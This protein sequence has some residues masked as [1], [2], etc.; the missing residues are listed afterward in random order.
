MALTKS[1]NQGKVN[2]FFLIILFLTFC[3]SLNRECEVF[4]DINS[5][6]T[7]I[8]IAIEKAG[9]SVVSLSTAKLVTQRHKDPVMG[10]RNKFFFKFF[11]EY[12]GS[13][14]QKRVE[15]P[16]GT[17]VIIDEGGYIVT[18]EHVVSSASRIKVILANGT[19]FDAVLVSSDPNIDLA[20]LK[21]D[22]PKPLP[23]IEMGISDDLMVGETVIAMG[24]PFGLGNSV[25]TGVLSALNRTLNFGDGNVNLEYK[26]LIQT[27][28][29][30]NPGNSGGPLINIEGKLIGINTAI[31][32]RA[33]GIGFAIPVNKVKDTLV[34]LLNFR[35]IKNVW[36]GVKVKKSATGID[37]IEIIDV[38]KRS[39]A[40]KSGLRKGD[41]ILALDNK[42]ISTLLDYEKFILNKNIN[43]SIDITIFR[44]DRK[45]VVTVTLTKTPI[46]SG[47]R[48]A[49]T[50]LGIHVQ[51]LTPSIAKSLGFR[52][53]RTGVLVAGI[54]DGGPAEEVQILPGY[55]I[56]R[57]GPY[58]VVDI[59]EL[60]IIL[61]QA[62]KGE[63]INIGL[64]WA[65]SYGEHRGYARVKVK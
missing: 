25:T 14:E 24:N 16:L 28:A 60:G 58:R 53:T 37:G 63:I 42:K 9:S 11:N 62:R 3:V 31:L 51:R 10:F 19:E 23:C 46:Q 18:N 39:P 50:K 22:S 65:D 26:D 34:S 2:S 57:V 47:E 55:L 43:D 8:V 15:R 20:I 7:D 13:F 12:F 49:L 29:L 61:R 6:R 45:K 32:S 54:E 40:K 30:I 35:E 5:R 4:G 41:I 48:I 56:V 52:S 17:G 64:I 33:Q 21:V 44:S 27:D 38:E 59:E 1:Q 36:L